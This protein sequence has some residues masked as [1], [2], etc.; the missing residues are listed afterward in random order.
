MILPVKTLAIRSVVLRRV[1]FPARQL[2]SQKW[3]SSVLP[4]SSNSIARTLMVIHAGQIPSRLFSIPSKFMTQPSRIYRSVKKWNYSSVSS[5][6][7]AHAITNIWVFVV[8]ERL[9]V[10][11][12]VELWSDFSSNIKN[13]KFSNEIFLS[14]TIRIINSLSYRCSSSTSSSPGRKISCPEPS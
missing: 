11:G 2:I 6:V 3:S 13:P 7:A 5:L 10:A 1:L 14:L 12:H 4:H 8:N 9:E